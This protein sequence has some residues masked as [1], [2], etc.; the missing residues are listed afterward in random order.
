MDV[1]DIM[2][3]GLQNIQKIGRGP[4]GDVFRA[5]WKNISFALKSFSD[6]QTLK[7]RK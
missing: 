5:D 7:E 3:F 4:F 2:T 6:E 1:S